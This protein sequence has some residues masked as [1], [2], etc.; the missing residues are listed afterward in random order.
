LAGRYPDLLAQFAGIEAFYD[1]LRRLHSDDPM[2]ELTYEQHIEPDPRF[3][4]EKVAEFIQLRPFTPDVRV[5]RINT[6]TVRECVTNF[7]DVAN[8]LGPTRYAWMLDT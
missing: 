6:R 3:G 4:Y 8:L 1:E 7:D 2:L 5:S